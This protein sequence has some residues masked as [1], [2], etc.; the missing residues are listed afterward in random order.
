MD[1]SFLV[2]HYFG[3]SDVSI[4]VF[5]A[6]T[7]NDVFQKVMSIL[8]SHL[9][10]ETSML[11]ALSYCFYEALDNVH[12]HSGKPLGTAITGFD[13]ANHRLKV[14]VADD[15][16][17]VWKSLRGNANYSDITE[18]DALKACLQD[19][20]TDGKGMGFGLYAMQRFMDSVGTEFVLHSGSHK[21]IMKDGKSVVAENGFWQG[22][23]LFM[24]LDTQREVNPQD[25]VDNRTDA[26]GEYNERFVELDE[27]TDLW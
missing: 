20:V 9:E 4:D 5:D 8:T 18:A 1:I 12:V 21:L 13:E 6:I 7:L 15:G 23:I 2:K 3:D 14:L 19:A 24:E 25:V 16:M 22:T 27:L 26:V 10:I 11:Q 17:G